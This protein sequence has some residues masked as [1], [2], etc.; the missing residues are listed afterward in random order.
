MSNPR[1]PWILLAAV[2]LLWG[3]QSFT[4]YLAPLTSRIVS[5][6]NASELRNA[7]KNDPSISDVDKRAF[8]AAFESSL[9]PYGKTVV[10]VISDERKREDQLA[11]AAAAA[12]RAAALVVDELKRDV[13]IR[14]VSLY[15]KRGRNGIMGQTFDAPYEDIDILAFSVTN[16]GKKTITS[17][18][19][20]ASLTNHGGDEIFNGEISS[21]ETLAP[22][23]SATIRI[24]HKPL[25]FEGDRARATSSEELLL[26]YDVTHIWYEDGSEAGK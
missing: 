26:S 3:W 20:T 12:A 15:V 19:S 14:P 1:L 21:G 24:D 16:R 23:A 4:P 8:A 10:Q 6:D 11:K 2:L 5:T 25:G 22:Q 18:R 9:Q 7:V 17:F 13:D